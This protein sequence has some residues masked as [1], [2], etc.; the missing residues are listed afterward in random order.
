MELTSLKVCGYSCLLLRNIVWPMFEFDLNQERD[1][2][3]YKTWIITEVSLVQ[4][5]QMS[6]KVDLVEVHDLFD[7]ESKTK[8]YYFSNIIALRQLCL[9][10]QGKVTDKYCVRAPI[11]QTNQEYVAM[12]AHFHEFARKI[13][14]SK[15]SG[16]SSGR[17]SS[18]TGIF[19]SSYNTR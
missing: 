5:R 17:Q 18:S 7:S 10:T 19:N 15:S 9:V 4:I 11:C 2:L 13:Q 14:Q 8:N 6:Q 12:N 1:G 16:S 3:V